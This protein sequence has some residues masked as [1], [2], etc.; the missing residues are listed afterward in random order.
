VRGFRSERAPCRAA[1]GH[2]RPAPRYMSSEAY[3]SPGGLDQS[4][5]TSRNA[6]SAA[7]TTGSRYLCPPV[8]V[9]MAPTTCRN[10]LNGEI[11]PVR[12]GRDCQGRR[13]TLREPGLASPSAPAIQGNKLMTIRSVPVTIASASPPGSDRQEEPT[14]SRRLNAARRE[15][16]KRPASQK[17]DE[18][19]DGERV[20]QIA[21][22]GS[23]TLLQRCRSNARA[24]R[25]SS[26]PQA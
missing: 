16:H 26:L 18:A 23:A 22:C 15:E 17:Q 9:V 5:L 19:P 2:G 6:S 14:P 20:S 24:A 12:H 1:V 25:R 4:S 8:I 7:C 10:P 13:L 3:R 11:Q 21:T